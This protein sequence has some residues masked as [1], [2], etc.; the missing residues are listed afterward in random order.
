MADNMTPVT[1]EVKDFTPRE[2][3][4][5]EY[6]FN[7]ETDMEGQLAGIP[8]GGFIKI[9]VKALNDGNAE[10]LGWMLDPTGPKDFELKYVSTVDD[11][12]MKTISGKEC[13]CIHFIEKWEEGKGHFEEITLACKELDNAGAKYV[14][15]WN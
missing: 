7:R 4:S 2:V 6:E 14:N 15:P 8:R 9:R 13:Y 5:V 10:L 11:K 12:A 1:F 3:L